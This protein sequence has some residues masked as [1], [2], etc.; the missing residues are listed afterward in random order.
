MGRFY[1]RNGSFWKIKFKK[2]CFQQFS[3]IFG[4]K[5]VVSVSHRAAVWGHD[6]GG[7]PWAMLWV[8]SSPFL[9]PESS[10]I[11]RI[12]AYGDWD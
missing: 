1:G 12:G 10:F 9:G 11:C 6:G 8:G 3:A 2:T 4:H 5:L 7:A